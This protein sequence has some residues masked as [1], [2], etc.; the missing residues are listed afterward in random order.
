VPI[1]ENAGIAVAVRVVLGICISILAARIM[2]R[3]PRKSGIIETPLDRTQG[4]QFCKD[5]KD[6]TEAARHSGWTMSIT[7]WSLAIVGVLVLVVGQTLHPGPN[8]L[9]RE[10]GLVAS[11]VGGLA[12]ALA[13]FSFSRA[14]AAAKA[15]SAANSGLGCPL[16]KQDR[17]PER[18]QDAE[19]V[20]AT[21]SNRSDRAHGPPT[22]DTLARCSALSWRWCWGSSV[23]A[24]RLS[25]KTSFFDSNWRL[26]RVGC[27][28]SE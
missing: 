13:Y 12:I 23:R 10:P 17:G 19:R 4:R 25:Q 16:P 20:L 24:H 21:F 27:T 6:L 26:R 11:V 3:G 18:R 1:I 28:A 2:R 15:A 9:L 8:S 7:A 14:D 22:L 5:L